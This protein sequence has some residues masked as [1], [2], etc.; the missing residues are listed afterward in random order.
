MTP[1]PALNTHLVVSNALLVPHGAASNDNVQ[2]DNTIALA[3]DPER[4]CDASHDQEQIHDDDA[5]D[6]AIVRSI[7]CEAQNADT[8]CATAIEKFARSR[9]FR[10]TMRNN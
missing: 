2:H 10:E 7:V 1:G 3:M 5:L 9:M 4:F 6:T 8:L